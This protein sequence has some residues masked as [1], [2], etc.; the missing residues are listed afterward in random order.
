M[1]KKLILPVILSGGSGT[2]L[3]PLSRS[4]FPKQ[5]LTLP[6]SDLSL[7]QQAIKRILKLSDCHNLNRILIITNEEN[8]FLALDQFSQFDLDKAEFFLEPEARNTAPAMT[9]A[10]LYAIQNNEDPILLAVPSDQ[11]IHDEK[12]FLESL[13]RGI[14]AADK[15]SMVVFGIKPD[16][17]ETGFGYIKTDHEVGI[18]G[19]I[20]VVEF[21]EKPNLNLAKAYINTGEYFWNSGIFVM[22]ASVWLDAIEECRP[23]IF[24]AAQKAFDQR[25]KDKKFIRPNL[26]LFKEIPSESIDYAVME[27]LFGFRRIKLIS[28]DAGWND[29]G[30]WDAFWKMGSKD[31]RGNV[32]YGDTLTSDTNNSLIYANDRLVVTH[33]IKDLIII[34]TIDSVL[35]IDRNQAQIVKDIVNKLTLQKRK[36]QNLHRKVLRPWGW[37]DTLDEGR[38]FK[39]KRI[40]VNPGASLSLQKHSKRAE[41]WVV[42][43]GIAEIICEDKKI[44]LNENESTFIPLG[45]KH[46]LS[47]P[48]NDTLE[49]IEVQSGS[50]LGEDD[51]ERLED[52]YGRIDLG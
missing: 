17:P 34:E 19:E 10:A 47:N 26:D 5:F 39:V 35:I 3:W 36:E 18:Y 11:V 28:L 42:V 30:S 45:S 21:K 12:V 49:I 4:G 14:D 2:R 37:F 31:D 44:I 6:D 41:H 33:G 32:F 23:D 40:L 29:L 16:R 51:I 25:T 13:R 9:L 20:N 22:K 15:G 27:K 50:Y 43:K 38:G 7:F 46:Q 52:N 1:T 48:G 8:R 24:V